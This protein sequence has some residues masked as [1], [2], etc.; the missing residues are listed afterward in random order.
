MDYNVQR[1]GT[2]EV[3]ENVALHQFSQRQDFLPDIYFLEQL[4]EALR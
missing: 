2:A 1:R 3:E 4:I